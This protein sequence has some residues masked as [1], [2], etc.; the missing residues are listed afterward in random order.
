[1]VRK[2]LFIKILIIFTSFKMKAQ[3]L[4]IE[5]PSKELV[6]FFRKLRAEKEKHKAKLVAGK[7]TYFPKSK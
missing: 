3:T 4:H 5:N 1:M 2:L 6:E 7:N